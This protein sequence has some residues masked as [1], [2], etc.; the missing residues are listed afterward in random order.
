MVKE[1]DRMP[2]FSI[3]DD[4][5]VAVEALEKESLIED[6]ESV[7]AIECISKARRADIFEK[8]KAAKLAASHLE[9]R[10]TMIIRTCVYK[11]FL[12]AGFEASIAMEVARNIAHFYA[13]NMI[14]YEWGG[15]LSSAHVISDYYNERMATE[16]NFEGSK[17]MRA[18]EEYRELNGVF[19]N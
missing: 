10:P 12:R 1:F 2:N 13:K 8:I 16:E 17:I 3:A 9:D 18:I 4:I 15:T 5:V 11:D 7:A 6:L 14:A 19:E